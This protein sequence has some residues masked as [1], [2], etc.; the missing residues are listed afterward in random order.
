MDTKVGLDASKI[1]PK[2]TYRRRHAMKLVVEFQLPSHLLPEV[3]LIGRDRG[4]L[5]TLWILWFQMSWQGMNPTR[6]ADASAGNG[7]HSLTSSPF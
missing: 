6:K 3:E 1:V 4:F 5:W 2:A 7:C